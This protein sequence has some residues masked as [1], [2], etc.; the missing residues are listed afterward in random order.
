VNRVVD[1]AQVIAAARELA[2][3]IAKQSALAVRLSKSAFHA[4]VRQG[5]EVGILFDSVAQA[6]CFESDDKR[7]RMS[8]FL[9][10]KKS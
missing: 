1:D 9:E 10:K 4:S 8:A 2:G 7:A 3:E 6:V 5:A